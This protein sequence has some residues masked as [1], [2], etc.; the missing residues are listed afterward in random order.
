[1]RA[2]APFLDQVLLTNQSALATTSA[3]VDLRGGLEAVV[4]V[5][6]GAGVSGGVVTIEEAPDK[7]YAGTWSVIQ[8]ITAPAA[9]TTVA[10]H[11][12]GTYNAVRARISTAIVGGTVGVRLAAQA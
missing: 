5:T 1:M 8:A 3:G 6:S 7:D 4:Y 9:S 10:A 11:L 2:P 12:T